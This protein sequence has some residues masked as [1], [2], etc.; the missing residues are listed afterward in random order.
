MA[1][2][3]A[4]LAL[5][6]VLGIGMA[7]VLSR[8]LVR[9][10]REL[11]EGIRAIASGRLEVQVPVKSHDEIGRLTEAFNEMTQELRIGVRARELFGS[12]VDSRV[13]RQLI[14]APQALGQEGERRTMTVMFCDLQGFTAMSEQMTPKGLVSIMNRHFTLMSEVIRENN[15]V[16]DKFIGDALMAYWGP[17]FVAE[18][19]QGT[20]AVASGITQQG[21]MSQLQAEL[22][23]LLG[24]KHAVPTLKLRIGIATGEVLV[25]S[26]GSDL[27]RN[28]TVMGDAV[29]LASRLENVN[30]LYGTRVLI[31]EETAQHLGEDIVLREIDSLIVIGQSH[32]VR[33]FEVLGRTGQVSVPQLDALDAFARGLDAYRKQAWDA[34][35]A[36]FEEVL[37]FTPGDGPAQL[38]LGR[39]EKLR[40]EPPR[41]E[42]NGV[43]VME[44]K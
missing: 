37:R 27:M 44:A 16:I 30:K 28:F 1:F 8:Q 4:T 20:L 43:W 34:G 31:A 40:R 23:D 12:Y 35:R 17:P 39:I 6:G 24:V 2:S 9:P 14:E 19:V 5:A 29:N 36:A 18:E 11:L 33:I 13:A 25:G 38:F 21:R 7:L 32:A 3:V 41:G 10:L 22:P 42:W 15:G 26:I